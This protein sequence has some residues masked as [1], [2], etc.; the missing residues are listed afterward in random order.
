MVVVRRRR[1]QRGI[2]TATVAIESLMA[3]TRWSGLRDGG[4]EW[5]QEDVFVKAKDEEGQRANA[6]S[7]IFIF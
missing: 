3:M 2:L 1:H 5:E 4:W 6:A 7:L